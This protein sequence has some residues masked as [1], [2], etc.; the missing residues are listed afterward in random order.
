MPPPPVVSRLVVSRLC[1]TCSVKH[2]F[3]RAAG[4]GRKRLTSVLVLSPRRRSPVSGSA[5]RALPAPRSHAPVGGCGRAGAFTGRA[6]RRRGPHVPR[7]RRGAARGARPRP[8]AMPPQGAAP[9]LGSGRRWAPRATRASRAIGLQAAP[10]PTQ[11]PLRGIT[12]AAFAGRR[13]ALFVE[14]ACPVIRLLRAWCL[15]EGCGSVPWQTFGHFT[16]C[17]CRP[18]RG[19]NPEPCARDAKASKPVLWP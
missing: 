14:R 13:C 4:C 10:H 8:H 9:P 3:T 6:H 16:D 17:R 1:C 19:A 2:T 5:P 7:G 15:F 11:A 18:V 12:R